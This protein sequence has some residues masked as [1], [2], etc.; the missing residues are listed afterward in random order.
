VSPEKAAIEAVW[1]HKR[2]WLVQSLLF[3]VWTAA[4]L[5]WF[6]LP[7]S[8]VSGLALSAALGISV[9]IGGAWLKRRSVLFYGPSAS[10]SRALLRPRLYADL[11]LLAALGAYL[12]YKLIG[13]H[14]RLAGLAMQTASLAMRFMAAYLLAV[15]A[16]LILASLVARLG[17]DSAQSNSG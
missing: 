13:W 4:A 16:W 11:A 2:F 8:S 5:S 3:A 9:L 6:W 7:D 10:V 12:P 1:R 14:P 17:A 15:S